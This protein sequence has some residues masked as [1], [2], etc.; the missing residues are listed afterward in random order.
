VEIEELDN[1]FSRKL[2]SIRK[3]AESSRQ[4]Y[5]DEQGEYPSLPTF[6]AHRPLQGSHETPGL[7]DPVD[8]ATGPEYVSQDLVGGLSSSVGVVGGHHVF[9]TWKQTGELGRIMNEDRE[10]LRTDPEVRSLIL[11][12]D[13][14]NLFRWSLTNE[15]AGFLVGHEWLSVSWS[16]CGSEAVG[17]DLHE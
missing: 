16:S 2:F 3:I 9:G 10:V 8:L 17:I 6:L 11:E 5:S 14:G 1:S 12:R 4:Q 7:P 15:A 13:Q